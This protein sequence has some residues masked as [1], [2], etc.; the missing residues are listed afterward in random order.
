ML[1]RESE[2]PFTS[3]AM[4]RRRKRGLAAEIDAAVGE[5]LVTSEKEEEEEE[6]VSRRKRE[7]E[8]SVHIKALN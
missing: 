2:G 7:R 5:S 6:G 8:G 3:T 1:E 4:Q